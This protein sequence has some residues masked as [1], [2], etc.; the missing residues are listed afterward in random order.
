MADELDRLFEDREDSDDLS[1]VESVWNLFVQLL[2]PLILLLTFISVIDIERYKV[3]WGVTNDEL[4][5]VREGLD[6]LLGVHDPEGVF[7]NGKFSLL[8][9]QKQRLLYKLSEIRRKEDR[10][11]RLNKVESIEDIH[12]TGTSIEDEEFKRLCEEV[13]KAVDAGNRESYQR[14]IYKLLLG[15]SGLNVPEEP[16]VQR[17]NEEEERF[18]SK[19]E[20]VSASSG[21][22]SRA[23]ANYIQNRIIEYV[24]GV[25]NKTIELQTGV[26]EK[27]FDELL[28]SPETA[29]EE[30]RENIRQL[31]RTEDEEAQLELSNKIY[32]RVTAAVRDD[33][34]DYG[35]LAKTWQQIASI[36]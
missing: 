5:D 22:I 26:L 23:N 27:I 17:H 8:D 4:E 21:K 30:T 3:R 11:F 14:N 28:K 13:K 12:I 35:F 29:D 34:R 9:A 16:E 6:S 15:N 31:L 36:E 10:K 19:Q 1:G 2:L 25:E 24:D 33:V 32:R 18:V 7:L 20:L